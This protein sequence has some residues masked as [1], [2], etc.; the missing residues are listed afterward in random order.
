MDTAVKASEQMERR[1]IGKPSWITVVI[2]GLLSLSIGRPSWADDEDLE[3]AALLAEERVEADR[4]RRSGDLRPARRILATHLEDDPEDYLALII[5]ARCDFDRNLVEAAQ[6]QSKRAFELAETAGD[7]VAL[8]EVARARIEFYLELGEH[9]NALAVVER[10]GAALTPQSDPTSAWWLS[11]ALYSAGRRDEARDLWAVGARADVDGDWERLLSKARCERA[12]GWYERASKTLI[13][14]D[15]TARKANG[16]GEA[17]VHAELGS[18]FFEVYREVESATGNKH[19][20]AEEY[21]EALRLNPRHEPALL[22]QLELYRY[23]WRRQ[24]HSSG[25]ILRDLLTLHGDSVDVR[26][27]A[28]SSALDS[29]RLPLAEQHIRKL[30]GLAPKR[31]EV[32]T[33]RATLNW[34]HHRR[35]EAQA[36]LAELA[37][38]DPRDGR[39]HREVGRHLCELYR[40]AEA[41]PFLKRSVAIDGSDPQAWTQLGRALANTGLETEALEALYRSKEVSG[42][43]LDAWR[44]NMRLVLERIRDDCVVADYDQLSFVWRPD[45]QAVLDV[46]LPKFYADAREELAKRYGHTPGHTRIEIFRKHQD[47]STRSTGFEGFPATGVCFGP[48]VT[49]LSPLSEMRGKFSWARTSF[50]EFSHV[51]H[52]GLSN[53]RCPR[54]I[55]EG[56]ATW[57]E[58]ARDPSWTRN[59]RRDLLDARANGNIIPVRELNDAFRGPRILFGYYQGGLL[60]EMLIDQHG[61]GPMV[62]LLEAFDQGLDLDAALDTVFALTP[63]EMDADFLK[64]V[65][66]KLAGLRLEPRWVPTSVRAMRLSLREQPP[67]GKAARD[68]WRED[69]LTV[70]WSSWQ[71]GKRIDAEE[72]L[73]TVSAMEPTPRSYF[74]RAEIALK[75]GDQTESKRLIE[76]GFEAGGEDFRSR[77]LLG[78][79]AMQ[80]GEQ[81]EALEQFKAAELAFPGYSDEQLSAEASQW[82]LHEARGETELAMAARERWLGW[83]ASDSKERLI[84]AR[85]L[86]KQERYEE[87]AQR[88]SEINDVDPFSR[89]LHLEWG[90]ALARAGRHREALREFDV[91]LLVPPHL[92]A[93]VLNYRGKP[94]T[95]VEMANALLGLGGSYQELGMTE[96]GAAKLDEML[97]LSGAAAAERAEQRSTIRSWREKS[98][99]ALAK[100]ASKDELDG[101]SSRTE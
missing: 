61:F 79:L 17:D 20:V 90:Q 44:K 62:R 45:A 47:F 72:A 38:E 13:F 70:A 53:N 97:G 3:L 15:K 28:A 39:P 5:L 63:E 31:R 26:L 96:D 65:D 81:A 59:M 60:C 66:T 25:E 57:E 35:E 49:A 27:A 55:T 43:R 54:W 14:A 33:E 93:D 84:V 1:T 46:Y 67:K 58:E 29:G 23:N 98:A 51:I 56:L 9:E 68:K 11:R 10:V 86:S 8:V 7:A 73:R 22:G 75:Q 101:S 91:A 40:F 69:W 52:L 100:D 50:H 42:G 76:Q 16:R 30:E 74:L 18:L 41:V 85:W 64:F 82:Q 71:I 78:M 83:N 24:R 99:A 95:E 88:F 19:S 21:R 36:I 2:L 34:V 77:M 89:K 12:A 32:R 6:K 92:D 87:S 94:V 80:A 4:L 48:V 37:K